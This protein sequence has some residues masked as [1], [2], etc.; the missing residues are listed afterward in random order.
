MV[1]VNRCGLVK[2]SPGKGQEIKMR[3]QRI[4]RL[5]VVTLGC[6]VGLSPILFSQ[7]APMSP[8]APME[9]HKAAPVST[10]LIVTIDGKAVT[11][12][13]ADLQAMP[14]KT[15]TVKNGHTQAEETYTGV[16]VSDVLAKGGISMETLKRVY[17]SYI[18]AEGTD[19]YWVLYSAS[20]IQS[21]L[22]EGQAIVA[23]TLDGKPLTTDGQF[24]IVETG[25]K[26]PARWVRNLTSLTVVT[27]E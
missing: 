17:H 22:R 8:A 21:G 3:M 5:R 19:H 4:P 20:E 23:L 14:Q 11:Y 27:V 16:A 6:L 12:T 7:M 26:R 2:R 10:T 15:V 13:L 18:K 1:G 24:K 25:E 9:A